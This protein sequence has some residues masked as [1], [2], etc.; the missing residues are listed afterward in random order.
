MFWP[1][2][3]EPSTLLGQIALVFGAGNNVFDVWP[4]FQIVCIHGLKS[5][6]H[7]KK[8]FSGAK[9]LFS[10]TKFYDNRCVQF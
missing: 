1:R 8:T 2:G 5:K 10:L 3:K 6:P 4:W 7:E 9:H